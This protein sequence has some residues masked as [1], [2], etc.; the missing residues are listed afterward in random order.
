MLASGDEVC[1]ISRASNSS[2]I[3]KTDRLSVAAAQSHSLSDQPPRSTGSNAA[4]DGWTET[5]N[6]VSSTL[7]E[8]VRTA[9]KYA[10]CA[11]MST[12]LI[13]S[14]ASERQKPTSSSQYR[15]STASIARALIE[16]FF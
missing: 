16:C 8:N 3:G 1:G 15:H 10:R 6:A 9:A 14:L 12:P 11:L 13:Q 4:D 7:E 5:I 2:G